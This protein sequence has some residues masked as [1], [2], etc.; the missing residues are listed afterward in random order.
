MHSLLP[1]W[2]AVAAAGGASAVPMGS[3]GLTSSAY[4]DAQ[5]LMA[6]VAVSNCMWKSW[7]HKNGDTMRSCIRR[8]RYE[9]YELSPDEVKEWFIVRCVEQ[10]GEAQRETCAAHAETHFAGRANQA[11]FGLRAQ[12]KDLAQRTQRAGRALV[13]GAQR[14]IG[15]AWSWAKSTF[16]RPSAFQTS[17]AAGR[18]KEAVVGAMQ[19][20]PLRPIFAPE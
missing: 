12:A 5:R 18:E 17:S 15:R 20:H 13:R 8:E 7:L 10:E 1:L 11:P 6:T 19:H 3:T 16:N 14:P 9:K 2:T 4:R